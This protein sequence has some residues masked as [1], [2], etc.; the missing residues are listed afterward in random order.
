VPDARFVIYVP[1]AARAGLERAWA[2]VGGRAGALM[3]VPKLAPAHHLARAGACDLFLDA[4][5]YQAGATAISAL[6]AGLP[7]LSR[8]GRN[9][10]SRLGSSIQ[11]TLGLDELVCPDT[12]AYV[13][14]AVQLARHPESLAAMRLRQAQ[15]VDAIGFFDP[16]RVARAIEGAIAE[17][18]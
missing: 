17:M 10:L 11:R 8:E 18:G 16:F 6:E 9:P 12:A 15:A 5:R 1:D 2:A 4:F 3:F 7:V 13:A 14:C